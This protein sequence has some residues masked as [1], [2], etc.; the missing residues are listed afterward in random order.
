MKITG[1]LSGETNGFGDWKS[2]GGCGAAEAGGVASMFG[3]ICGGWVRVGVADSGTLSTGKV[4]GGD[5]L[6]FVSVSSGN[7]SGSGIDGSIVVDSGSRVT[8]DGDT[9]SIIGRAFG[10]SGSAKM[11]S[12]CERGGGVLEESSSASGS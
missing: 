3:L 4:G 6:L 11:S 10:V 8:D 2:I 5:G 1:S 12:C 7:D 9:G